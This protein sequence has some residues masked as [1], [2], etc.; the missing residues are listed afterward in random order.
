MRRT[1][2]HAHWQLS[3]RGWASTGQKLSYSQI[4]PCPARVPGHVHQDLLA[5]GVIS[6]PF[7]RLHELGVQWVDE[8][9]FCYS[10]EF[11]WLPAAEGSRRVLRFEG[12]DTVCQVSLNGQRIAESD[13]MFIPLEV[14]VSALLQPGSNRLEVNFESAVRVGEER[15]LKYYEEQALAEDLERFDSRSFVRK[16]QY[17]YGWDWGPRLVSSGIWRPVT[18]L[19]FSSRFVLVRV[20]QTHAAD[21]SVDLELTSEVEGKG[22]VVHVWGETLLEDGVLHIARPKLWWPHGLG[23][24]HLHTL[25]SFLLPEAFDVAAL[26]NDP[27]AALAK[28]EASALDQRQTRVGLRSLRLLQEA[29]SF[30]R[31]FTFEVNGRP[32]WA[33]GANWIPDHSFPSQVGPAALRARLQ[34]ACDSGFNMLRVWGGGLYESDEF[35]DQCDELGLLVWQDFPF[36]CAYYPDNGQ[37]AEAVGQ[38]ASV[39]IRRLRNHASLALWCGNNENQQMY[40]SRWGR[41]DHHPPRL[42][43]EHLYEE[44]LPRAVA[45]HDP[46]RSYVPTSPHGGADPNSG[47]IGDQHYWD[48]WHGRGDWVHYRDSTA[49]FSSE[50]GFAS[51]CSLEAWQAVFEVQSPEAVASLAELPVRDAVVRWHDKTGKGQETFLGF[52]ALHY[53]ESERLGDWVYYSQ[54]NQRDAIR[55]AIEHYRRSEFCKGSLIWQL[56]DCWPVQSWAL[57]DSLG[58]PKPAF[59]ELERLHAPCLVSIEVVA[60]KARVWAS[61][62][63]VALD[64]CRSGSLSLEAFAL[65][66][67]ERLWQRN[68]EAK[69]VAGQR[70]VL[71]ETSLERLDK[72]HTLLVASFAG[73]T[74]RQLLDEPKNLKLPAPRPLSIAR[75]AEGHVRVSSD[76][77]LVDLVLTEAGATRPFR[78]NVFTLERPGSMLVSYDGDLQQLSARSLAGPHEVRIE[79]GAAEQR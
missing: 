77:P 16:A 76:M 46:D 5:R 37:Y 60:G 27:S 18:L 8:R 44:V 23:T 63:N 7:T 11:Q 30:G 39:N 2:L 1:S 15:R 13:N 47:G 70:A 21:G 34:A 51:S 20:R 74:A 54:L 41:A 25:R 4:E 40:Q 24:A 45:E 32:L 28:L 17:M 75:V 50:Y 55:A 65:G 10:T 62:D 67:G 52:V 42:Y 72:A 49:R 9:D 59:Y 73:A 31:S 22:R 33:M 56:N 79:S 19:E 3:D 58:N 35:Y 29:D 38:E 57:I 69:L 26:G 12:L 14:D 61:L 53:P 66:S 71:L 68:A 48:V 36:A 78:Q 43:G 6:D 64:D